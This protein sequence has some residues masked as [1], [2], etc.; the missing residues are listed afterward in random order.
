MAFDARSAYQFSISEDRDVA[1]FFAGRDHE[2]GKFRNALEGARNRRASVFLGLGFRRGV[3]SV[4]PDG[5]YD[6][7]IPSMGDWLQAKIA[8]RPIG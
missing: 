7:A 5:T 1:P 3:L 2:I 6:V 4:A 8:S